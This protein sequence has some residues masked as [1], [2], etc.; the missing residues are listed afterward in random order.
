L[1]KRKV[2]SAQS[3]AAAVQQYNGTKVTPSQVR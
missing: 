1:T 3:V 2:L